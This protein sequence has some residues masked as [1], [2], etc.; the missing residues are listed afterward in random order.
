MRQEPVRAP[1]S[2]GRRR[3][4]HDETSPV[5]ISWIGCK[6]Q[7]SEAH[8][9]SWYWW[10][11]RF[12]RLESDEFALKVSV[13]F[14]FATSTQSG[15]EPFRERN[16]DKSAGGFSL[17]M[18]AGHSPIYPDSTHKVPKFTF[19]Y[20]QVSMHMQ[21]IKNASMLVCKKALRSSFVFRVGASSGATREA[22]WYTTLAE[23][24][25]S[26]LLLYA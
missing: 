9:H 3:E 14:D 2:T 7:H 12:S 10:R 23:V 1:T 19:V 25:T 22:S 24:R 18:R 20:K 4:V 26:F 15:H 13:I 8:G 21:A 11:S 17:K 5:D 6:S 16:F